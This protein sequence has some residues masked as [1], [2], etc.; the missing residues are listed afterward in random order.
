MTQPA[1]DLRPRAEALAAGLP[2]LLLAAERL[3][4]VLA[5]GAHGMRR[6]G[7]GEDFWQYRP[8]APGDSAR[9]IDWRR[10]ARSDARFVRDREAQ[11]AQSAALWLDPAPG[12]DWRGGP[13]RPT[14]RDRAALLALALGLVLL[15]GG[16]RVAALGQPPRG[17]AAQATRLA[18]GLIPG[19]ALRPGA[20]AGLRPGSH[21]VLFSDFFDDVAVY[22]D[23]LESAARSGLTGLLVQ[24]TDPDEDSFPFQGHIHFAGAGPDGPAR[25][26]RDAGGLRAAYLAR[27]AQRRDNLRDLAARCGWRFEQH[28]TQSDPAPALARMAAAL[29]V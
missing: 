29:E 19:T 2:A 11:Q 6:A 4:A 1:P 21:L 25:L 16:E 5:P 26:T 8:A 17:G 12:M 28:D 7:S 10:S 15:R 23:F 9:S 22:T 24:V 20:D 3:A 18:A 13:G 14:K 27:L